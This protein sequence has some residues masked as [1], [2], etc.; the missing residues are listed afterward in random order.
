MLR[1]Q[2]AGRQVS[3]SPLTG[4]QSILPLSVQPLRFAFDISQVFGYDAP[5]LAQP[6]AMPGRVC[7]VAGGCLVP[8]FTEIL[9]SGMGVDQCR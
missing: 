2:R 3:A 8:G 6:P 5:K 4:L 7:R 1:Q 9:R